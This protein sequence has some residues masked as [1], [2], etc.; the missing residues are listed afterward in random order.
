MKNTGKLDSEVV[1]IKTQVG[2]KD[3]QINACSIS[4]PD[5][6]SLCQTA[7]LPAKLN[8]CVDARVMLIVFLID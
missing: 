8:L 3:I 6:I 2:N 1:V 4:I 7:N 5:N